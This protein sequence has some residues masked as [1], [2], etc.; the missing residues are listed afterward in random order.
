MQFGQFLKKITKY[1]QTVKGMW[2][3]M[4][5]QTLNCGNHHNWEVGKKPY[6]HKDSNVHITHKTTPNKKSLHHWECYIIF[7]NFI[8][9]VTIF[10][11]II[12]YY[13]NLHVYLVPIVEVLVSLYIKV[14]L[15]CQLN[16]LDVVL[17]VSIIRLNLNIARTKQ[18]KTH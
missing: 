12:G 10:L 15:H 14:C 16:C 2:F 11:E 8:I 1:S 13:M 18:Q 9:M 6:D 5:W 3:E 17:V 4:F 7:S